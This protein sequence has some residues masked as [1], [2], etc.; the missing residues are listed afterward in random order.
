[1]L[2]LIIR[3]SY[4]FTNIK[5]NKIFLV[6]FSSLKIE[7]NLCYLHGQPCVYLKKLNKFLLFL[8]F[9][10]NRHWSD[11]RP[12]YLVKKRDVAQIIFL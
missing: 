10:E 1:M 5:N 9:K 3:N 2:V 12:N 6:H 11:C 7:T 8:Y 4:G